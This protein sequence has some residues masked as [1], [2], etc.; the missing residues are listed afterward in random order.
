MIVHAWKWVEMLKNFK[1]QFS[2]SLDIMYYISAKQIF[3]LMFA[4]ESGFSAH[5][6]LG[7]VLEQR[8]TSY[9]KK[10]CNITRKIL[11]T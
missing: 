4:K 2:V 6:S 3:I 5:L 8:N 7:R 10:F 11:K 9:P 1:K